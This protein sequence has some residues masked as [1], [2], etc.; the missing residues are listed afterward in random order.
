VSEKL[1]SKSKIIHPVSIFFKKLYLANWFYRFMCD[2]RLPNLLSH[3]KNKKYRNPTVHQ[4]ITNAFILMMILILFVSA[5]TNT[6]LLLS[7]RSLKKVEAMVNNQILLSSQ[8]QVQ[9][10]Q[11]NTIYQ[12]YL[13]RN[14]SVS[15]L[16]KK[17]EEIDQTVQ[18]FKKSLEMDQ[19]NNHLLRIHNEL[20]NLENIY[21]R[22]QDYNSK[23]TTVYPFDA[24]PTKDSIVLLT[25]DRIE[26]LVISSN[27]IQ[28]TTSAHA[29]PIFKEISSRNSTYMFFS[30]IIALAALGVALLFAIRI[31]REVVSFR[32]QIHDLTQELV[33][34][35]DTMTHISSS[36]KL[37]AEQS[38]EQI[39]GMSNTI[40][41]LVSGTDEI[42][43]SILRIDTGIQQVTELNKELGDST[44]AAIDFVA[45]TQ[46][47]I[48][49]FS[50]RLDNNIHDV[51]QV[52]DLL[53]A[54]ME[55]IANTSQE[56][57]ILSI[58]MDN[59]RSILTSISSIS[60]QTN[61]LALNA[62]IEAA[63]AGEYGRGFTVVAEEIR[64]LAD[65]SA[66]NTYEIEIIIS[67]LIGFTNISLSKLDH[68]TKTASVSLQETK[69]ITQV[70]DDVNEIFSTIVHNIDDIK[71]LTDRVS[72]HSTTTSKKSEEIRNYSQS[73]SAKTQQFLSSIQQF[74]HTLDEIGHKTK[75]SLIRSQEQFNL[76]D[77]QK[78]NIDNI[79]QTVK[80]L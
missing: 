35:T 1:F 15:D 6:A 36:V 34:E 51:H 64:S 50:K 75:S 78:D 54:A 14:F 60:R 30:I 70:F 67:D 72:S 19:S 26:K 59:I 79:Y 69:K 40:D 42:A 73:I 48:N 12:R 80:Q 57:A 53:H 41:F 58:K 28:E 5:S 3:K 21:K 7:N 32:N 33:R 13:M 24:D 56:V 46:H 10:L 29:I 65:Q 68:S 52:V 77:I 71:H 45:Q 55:E 22:I 74:A 20:D 63:R 47:D 17:I 62:S 8:I 9:S 76:I 16:E 23:L 11:F 39:L 66:R 18:L 4:K 37:D 43:A 31:Y 49:H 61:L 38:S 2:I 44:A 27:L 25:L